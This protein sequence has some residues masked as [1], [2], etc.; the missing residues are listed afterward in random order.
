MTFHSKFK[1]SLA[2]A[3]VLS[4]AF[5]YADVVIPMYL[6]AKEGTGK[7]IGTVTAKDTAYGLLLTP[8]LQ[9][10]T[11]GLH[12]FHIHINPSCADNGAAAGGHVDPKQTGQHLGPYQQGHLGDLPGLVVDA[13]GKATLPLLAPRLSTKDLAH[14][15]LMIHAGGDNYADTPS[16]LG[17]GGARFA[18]GVMPK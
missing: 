17:G 7:Y 18:C 2:L 13:Q 1:I 9:D 10:L 5:A 11:P 14:H 3:L 8:N 12:G 4:S 6:T 15:S 16:P